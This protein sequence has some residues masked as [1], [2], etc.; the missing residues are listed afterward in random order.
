MK[1]FIDQK[2]LISCIIDYLNLFCEFFVIYFI[3][4]EGPGVAHGNFF[5]EKNKFGFF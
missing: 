3:L 1:T 5:F 2:I 4:A